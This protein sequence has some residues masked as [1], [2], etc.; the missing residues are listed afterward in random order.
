MKKKSKNVENLFAVINGEGRKSNRPA[1]K[2]KLFL[3]MR[4]STDTNLKQKY[5]TLGLH[6]EN[7]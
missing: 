3:T 6:L 4:A 7:K 2:N 5:K 1:S